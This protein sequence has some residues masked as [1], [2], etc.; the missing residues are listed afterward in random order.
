MLIER[1]I[2]YEKLILSGVQVSKWYP[3]CLEVRNKCLIKR[4]KQNV[5]L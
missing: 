2:F 3:S 4:K 1:L 5:S